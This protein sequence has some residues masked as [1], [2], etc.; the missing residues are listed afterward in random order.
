[1][2]WAASDNAK[3]RDGELAL[4][5]ATKACE[6]SGWGNSTFLDTLATAYAE[7]GDFDAAVKWQTKAIEL[8][9]EKTEQGD[10]RTRL[11]LYQE[12]KP[13]HYGGR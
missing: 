12:K 1:M 13:Y 2:E 9:T 10:F 3:D 5:A 7:I 11:K 8:L 6:L 4:E